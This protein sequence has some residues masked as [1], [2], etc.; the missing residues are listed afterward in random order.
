MSN[1]FKKRTQEVAPPI[2][3]EQ[4]VEQWQAVPQYVAVDPRDYPQV[5]VIAASLASGSATNSQFNLKRLLIANPEAKRVGII[6]SSLMA[7]QTQQQ[8]VIR[9]IKKRVNGE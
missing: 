4:V 3:K 9:S 7:T 5:T 2:V 1:L 6:V 8:Y